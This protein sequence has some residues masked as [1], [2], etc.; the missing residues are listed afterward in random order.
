[1]QRPICTEL[2]LIEGIARFC[3][4]QNGLLRAHIHIGAVLALD[5]GPV[6]RLLFG[7]GV[8]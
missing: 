8:E 3:D 4:T 5:G 6:R 7:H 1:M 2:K